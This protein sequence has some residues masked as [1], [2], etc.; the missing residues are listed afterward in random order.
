M[1]RKVYMDAYELQGNTIPGA[2]E[3]MFRYLNE[4]VVWWNFIGHANTTGWT[5]ENQL[6]YS[7][8]N[9][10]Y[11]RHWPFIYAATCDFMRLDGNDITGGE[12]LYKE[13]Y[14]G[15]IGIISAV[16]PVYITNKAG[17]RQ[18]WA[19]PWPDAMTKDAFCLRAKSIVWQRTTSVTPT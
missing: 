16:R 11:L 7:D 4:G 17:F 2:R 3:A 15:A 9:N 12:I 1:I 6:S 18:Q 14:G 13:R 10:M 5:H 8:L 19:V